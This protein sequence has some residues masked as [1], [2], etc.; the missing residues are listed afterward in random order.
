MIV[1]IAPLMLPKQLWASSKGMLFVVSFLAFLRTQGN[2]WGG[3]PEEL[4]VHLN[5][6]ALEGAKREKS[7]PRNPQTMSGCLRLASPSLRKIGVGSSGANPMG[8]D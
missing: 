7:W 4:L 1:P 3:K 6:F 2:N 8:F 5:K